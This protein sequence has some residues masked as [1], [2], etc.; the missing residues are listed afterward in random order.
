[1]PR[2]LL[3]AALWVLA[4][5]HTPPGGQQSKRQAFYRLN[6]AAASTMKRNTDF[7]QSK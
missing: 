7:H 3:A 5:G 6:R 4:L 1:M 2:L